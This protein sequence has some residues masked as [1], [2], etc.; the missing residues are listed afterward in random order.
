MKFVRGSTLPLTVNPTIGA[1]EWLNKASK[2]LTEFNKDL[3]SGGLGFNLLYPDCT[4]VQNLPGS[5]ESFSLDKNKQ[6]IGKEYSQLNDK[7]FI[8]NCYN[9]DRV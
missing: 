7:H 2:K 9:R 8:I 4:K 1:E 6:E 5:E 3:S